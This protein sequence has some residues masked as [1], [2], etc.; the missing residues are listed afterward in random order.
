MVEF[1]GGFVGKRMCEAV[2]LML[3]IYKILVCFAVVLSGGCVD[4]YG[5]GKT[6]AVKIVKRQV[7]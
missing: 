7:Q 6:G 1:L 5:R 2:S 3:N 4:E